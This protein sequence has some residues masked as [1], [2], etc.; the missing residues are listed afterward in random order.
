MNILPIQ[1]MI[2][3]IN[4]IGTVTICI[5]IIENKEIYI[6][7]GKAIKFRRKYFDKEIS[8]L[9]SIR[10]NQIGSKYFKDTKKN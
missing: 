4:W 10:M 1:T 2:K 5:L 6:I 8:Y 3:F 9:Q 7:D